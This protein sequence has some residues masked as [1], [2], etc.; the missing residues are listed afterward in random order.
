MSL[1]FD[2]F[3]DQFSPNRA[4][5]LELLRDDGVDLM[6]I[7]CSLRMKLVRKFFEDDQALLVLRRQPCQL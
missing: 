6:F 7:I 4:I 5:V 2:T 3:L 1:P